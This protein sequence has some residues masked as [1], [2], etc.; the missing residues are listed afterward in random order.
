[1]SNHGGFTAAGASKRRSAVI[2]N[3][4]KDSVYCDTDAIYCIEKT[5]HWIKHKNNG[6]DYIEC[7]NCSTWFLRM[8]LV[9][10]SYCPNCGEKKEV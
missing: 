9:R 6:I 7:S 4:N 5:G 2:K 8:H 3:I 1:M 10:N